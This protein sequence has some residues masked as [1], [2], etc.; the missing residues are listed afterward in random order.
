MYKSGE[1]GQRGGNPRAVWAA[2]EPEVYIQKSHRI[3]GVARSGQS[4]SPGAL[5]SVVGQACPC[6][7]PLRRGG[8]SC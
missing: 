8:G 2:C 5:H 7:E 3:S 6:P 1:I 4:S